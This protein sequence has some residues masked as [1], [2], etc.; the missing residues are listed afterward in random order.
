[1]EGMSNSPKMTAFGP[2]GFEGTVGKLPSPAERAG[3]RRSIVTLRGSAALLSS[4]LVFNRFGSRTRLSTPSAKP[5]R[6]TRPDK[7]ARQPPRDPLCPVYETM[8][9][10]RSSQRPTATPHGYIL[11]Q[12]SESVSSE[13]IY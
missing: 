12:V 10:R 1:M 6:D 13:I 5:F 4:V 7:G 3:R 2:E 11:E 8:T 9:I